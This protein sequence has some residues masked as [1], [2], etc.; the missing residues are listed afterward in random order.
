MTYNEIIE[1][2]QNMLATAREMVARL[3]EELAEAEEELAAREALLVEGLQDAEMERHNQAPVAWLEPGDIIR[4]SDKR[5]RSVDRI[6]SAGI[7]LLG[8]SPMVRVHLV[9]GESEVV[10]ADATLYTWR[11]R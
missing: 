3:T 4:M 10:S 9:G 6:E 1:S 5:F 2:R 8:G 7:D 11:A